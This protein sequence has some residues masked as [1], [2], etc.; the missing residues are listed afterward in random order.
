MPKEVSVTGAPPPLSQSSWKLMPM[1]AAR[2]GVKLEREAA[3]TRAARGR[4]V[5]ETVFMRG[6]E[7]E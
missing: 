2:L 7:E 6:D 4:E 1:R 5:R 3:V